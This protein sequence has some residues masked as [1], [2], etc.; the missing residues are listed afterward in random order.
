M[1]ERVEAR[2]RSRSM[3]L[4]IRLV[5]WTAAAQAEQGRSQESKPVLGWGIS[6]FVK[7]CDSL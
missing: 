1:A 7:L 5:G 3:F 2:S 6:Y 4:V